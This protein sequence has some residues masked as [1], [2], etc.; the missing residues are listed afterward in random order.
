MK[1]NKKLIVF[2]IIFILLVVSIVYRVMNP[3][4]HKTV[5]TLT[6]T[7]KIPGKIPGK[8]SDKTVNKAIV[9]MQDFETKSTSWIQQF[10][11]KPKMPGKVFKDLFSVYR[12]EENKIMGKK[13]I[14]QN[15]NL[16]R[17]DQ[18]T[19]NQDKAKALIKIKEYIT[20]YK[21]YGIYKSQGKR[22]VFLAK[23]KM[24]LVAKTGDRLDGKYQIED[25]QD[26]YLKIKALDLNETLHL[27]MREFKNE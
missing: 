26:K 22:A 7:G 11:T 15:I 19:D 21:W 1:T 9:K 4:V 16:N 6:Y 14:T 5:D 13:N 12:P 20:S 27:D 23:D 10:L 25:I 24:V 3:F 17:I 8:I 18:T 2:I